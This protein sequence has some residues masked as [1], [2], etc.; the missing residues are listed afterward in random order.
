MGWGI[1]HTHTSRTGVE[2]K[3]KKKTKKSVCAGH[4][5]LSGMERKKGAR[6]EKEAPRR[7]RQVDSVDDVDDDDLDTPYH[8]FF[9]PCERARAT[10]VEFSL[11][12]SCCSVAFE[13]LSSPVFSP[14]SNQIRFPPTRLVIHLLLYQIISLSS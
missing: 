9:V 13:L 6:M 4:V 11:F 8:K 12:G 1:Q 10:Q 2:R 3:K 5:T 7:R 14:K